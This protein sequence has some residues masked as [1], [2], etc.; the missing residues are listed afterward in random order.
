MASLNDQHPA[1]KE[2]VSMI[3]HASLFCQLLEVIPRRQ[4]QR[5]VLSRGTEAHSK[6]FSS[7]DQ[8]V[9][10]LFLQIAQ[11]KS[12]REICG[13]LACCLGKLTHLGVRRAPK[14]STLAY[15]N[16]HRDWEMFRDLYSV[17]LHELQASLPSRRKLTFCSRLFS[18]D[19]SVIILS[20]ALFDWKQYRTAKGA[21]KLHLLLDHDGY[22][23]VFAC[24]DDVHVHEINIAK[25]LR[26]PVGSVVVV[27]RGYQS[28][29]MFAR[30]AREGVFFVTR[31][32]RRIAY[33]VIERRECSGEIVA[34]EVVELTG[35]PSSSLFPYSLRRVV[36]RDPETGHELVFM[37]SLLGLTG[38]EVA[39]VYKERW[40]IETFFRTLKQNLRVKTFIGTSF[41]AICSQIWTALISILVLRYLQLR[42]QIGWSF[43]SLVALFR[44]NLLVYRD[45]WAWLDDPFVEPPPEPASTQLA[46]GF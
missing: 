5:L 41:N 23:P 1:A 26:F 37:T 33:R 43:S 7:W 12:L 29:D 8:F 40:Q 39:A 35:R 17:I 42:S 34:D 21:M 30:W 46:L 28:F 18:L 31:M 32:R 14:R 13:G 38:E 22:L 25:S 44:M 4:F 10:L 45:L 11:A 3:R 6:G 15:A 19:A 20:V 24:L 36:R 9:A 16:E 2:D 27:D